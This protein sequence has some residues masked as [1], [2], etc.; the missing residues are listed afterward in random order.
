MHG[1][2]RASLAH[3]HRLLRGSSLLC[4]LHVI[5]VTGVR[6]LLRKCLSLLLDECR[7]LGLCRLELTLAADAVLDDLQLVAHLRVGRGRRG[8]ASELKR[9]LGWADRGGGC[10]ESQ[11]SGRCRELQWGGRCSRCRKLQWG[12]RRRKL[13][14]A[15]C[16]TYRGDSGVARSG[17][18][19]DWSDR[20]V[21]RSHACAGRRRVTT[22]G[23]SSEARTLRRHEISARCQ[24]V[25]LVFGLC[26]WSA[27]RVAALEVS[28]TTEGAT[29]GSTRRERVDK[30]VD[31]LITGQVLT[32]QAHDQTFLQGFCSSFQWRTYTEADTE[33][34]AVF[35]GTL[36]SR[37]AN[38]S[39]SFTPTCN[40]SSRN[41]LRQ[42]S[43]TGTT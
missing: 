24:Q 41:I 3:G 20:G 5:Q 4:L 13:Q 17:R 15:G 28:D 7:L 29:D 10:R 43:T 37:R 27:V 19:V 34:L 40:P 42:R 33:T 16:A 12:G 32:R 30:S 1:L 23:E 38:C 31:G 25:N 9:T 36:S 39:D 6:A 8:S 35:S 14:W 21:V 22:T 26:T 11:Q 2:G 18:R